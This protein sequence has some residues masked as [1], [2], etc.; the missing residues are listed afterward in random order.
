M[1]HSDARTTLVTA[2]V[3]AITTATLTP[4]STENAALPAW[5]AD[6]FDG[7]VGT[8][9]AQLCTMADDRGLLSDATNLQASVAIGYHDAD[10]WLWVGFPSRDNLDELPLELKTAIRN[11]YYLTVLGA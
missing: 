5:I 9:D 7:I 1:N 6:G 10:V 2:L 11:R 4:G 8:S 3:A